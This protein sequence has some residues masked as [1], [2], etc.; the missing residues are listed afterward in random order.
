M[1]KKQSQYTECIVC[2]NPLAAWNN[3]YCSVEC[4]NVKRASTRTASRVS[5]CATCDQPLPDFARRYCSDACK[6]RAPCS[7]CGKNTRTKHNTRCTECQRDYSREYMRK[8]RGHEATITRKQRGSLDKSLCITCEKNPR[9]EYCSYC[10]DCLAERSRNWRKEN[11]E[12]YNA[13]R[14]EQRDL[15]NLR[16]DMYVMDLVEENRQRRGISLDRNNAA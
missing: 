1:T 15:A 9:L 2:G 5:R 16:A 13:Y 4:M 14:R 12:H 3:R 8:R 7:V 11:R 6:L 10:A